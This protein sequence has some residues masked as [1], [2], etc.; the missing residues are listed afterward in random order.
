[1]F[2]L[3][4][5]KEYVPIGYNCFTGILLVNLGLRKNAYPLD[6]VI[7]NPVQVLQY[8]KT[9]FENYYLPSA[10][11]NTNYMNQEFPWFKNNRYSTHYKDVNYNY[12]ISNNM[13]IYEENKLLFE[14]RINRL[15]ELLKNNGPILFVYTCEYRVNS[16]RT[17]NYSK[18]MTINEDYHYNIIV[19]LNKH[20]KSNFPLLDFDILII[21]INKYDNNRVLDKD[22]DNDNIIKININIQVND[23]VQNRNNITEILR[24]IFNN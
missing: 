21:Y 22:Y 18:Y 12:N 11:S 17:D 10:D 23:D 1:M 20:I 6:W 3:K 19:E 7:C 2:K 24:P 5:Y 15:L 13:S 4:K 8:F 9:N 16:T 14:K